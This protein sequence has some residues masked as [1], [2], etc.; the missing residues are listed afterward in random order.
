MV[1]AVTLRVAVKLN[2]ALATVTLPL[3]APGKRM[4]PNF[5]PIRCNVP[6]VALLLLSTMR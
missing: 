4:M 5:V 3:T 1:L 2:A 6:P